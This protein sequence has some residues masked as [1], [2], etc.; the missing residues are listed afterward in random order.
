MR[1]VLHRVQAEHEPSGPRVV[2][3][4]AK[5]NLERH[6]KVLSR[7][8]IRQVDTDADEARQLRN[9]PS[10]MVNPHSTLYKIWQLVR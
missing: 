7:Y 1:R 3:D 2:V 8:K 5:A 4:E 10:F 6:L 9:L